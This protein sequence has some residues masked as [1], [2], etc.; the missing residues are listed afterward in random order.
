MDFEELASR[1]GI[2]GE[3]FTELVELFIT[4]TRSDM[5]KILQAMARDNPSDASAA[6]HSI[7]GAAANL[8]FEAMADLAKNMEYKGKDGSLEGFEDM[9]ADMQAHLTQVENQLAGT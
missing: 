3:D 5:D 1:I 7:K 2:D 8:G 9:M 6:A 4:T